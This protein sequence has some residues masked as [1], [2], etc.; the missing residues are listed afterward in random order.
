M[1][2]IKVVLLLTTLTVLSANEYLP[3]NNIVQTIDT[4]KSIAVIDTTTTP[5]VKVDPGIGF[6]F[7]KFAKIIES[8]ESGGDPRAVSCSKMYIGLYQIGDL[9]LK[10]IGMKNVSVAKFIRNPDIFP[11]DAQLLALEKLALK[12]Q[13][14]LEKE[15]KRF[16]GKEVHGYTITKA[17]LLGA[18]HHIGVGRVKQF[19]YTGNVARDGSGVPLTTFIK[20]MVDI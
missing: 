8:K 5:V 18:A 1:R 12:N 4:S 2:S 13:Q 17:G 11:A 6:D 20:A 10:E 9:A 7:K 16:V 3:V 19:L 14:Y 15:I